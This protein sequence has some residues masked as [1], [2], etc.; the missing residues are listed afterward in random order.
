MSDKVDI[1]ADYLTHARFRVLHAGDDYDF[2]FRALQEG[3][4]IDLSGAKIWLTIK[5]KS[6]DK[7]PGLLQYSTEEITQIEITDE[8]EGYFVVHF[9]AAD[10]ANL[11]GVWLYDIKARLGSGKLMRFAR[12][13]IEFLAN[14]TRASN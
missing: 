3:V 1:T 13:S 5:K 12:G 7:D 11:E 9:G 8:D 14:L 10:T 6:S 4:A 2:T